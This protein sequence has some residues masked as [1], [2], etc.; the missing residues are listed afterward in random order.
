MK[1]KKVLMSLVAIGVMA[2]TATGFAATKGAAKQ[3]GVK[4]LL[5]EKQQA[6]ATAKVEVPEGSNYFGT[7]NKATTYVVKYQDPAT[8]DYYDVI[9]DKA[10]K[11]VHH[12]TISGSNFPGS[13][14]I[15]KKAADVTAKIME[16]YP[17]ASNI[18]V[19]LE[20]DPN[21]QNLKIYKATFTTP[22]FNGVAQLNPATCLYGH[23]ELSYK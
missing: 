5:T 16:T 19:T 9:I 21:G 4:A 2:L 1:M 8:L 6:V 23:R 18:V 20:D 7:S 13:V 14:T 11:K 22:K 3:D 10:T 15:N 17:N 12:V